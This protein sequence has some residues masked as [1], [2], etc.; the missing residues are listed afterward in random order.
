[1][2]VVCSTCLGGVSQ[3]LFRVAGARFFISTNYIQTNILHC[4]SVHAIY[5]A[6]EG[7][8]ALFRNRLSL[9]WIEIP[10][11][12]NYLNNVKLSLCI[13]RNNRRGSNIAGY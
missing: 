5:W 9:S 2:T 4:M 12:S 6:K 8:Y 13:A 10:I 3:P 1:M 11:A 7:T